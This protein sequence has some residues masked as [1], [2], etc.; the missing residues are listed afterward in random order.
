MEARHQFGGRDPLAGGVYGERR[1]V[2]VTTGDHQHLMPGEA[3]VARDD[4]ARQERAD[5]LP[6]VRAATRIGPGDADQD[7]V[8]GAWLLTIGI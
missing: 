4:V 2:G 5:D 3:V 1:A 6:D 7:A 8:G